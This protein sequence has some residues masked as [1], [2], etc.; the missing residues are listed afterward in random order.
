MA[1][2]SGEGRRRVG[3]I[4][5]KARRVGKGEEV[6]RRVRNGSEEKEIFAFSVELLQRA[7]ERISP[8]F[9]WTCAP[10]WGHKT[11]S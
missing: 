1:A 3:E 4:Y 10:D 9:L 11:G 7:A 5:R 2:K 6:E 8:C